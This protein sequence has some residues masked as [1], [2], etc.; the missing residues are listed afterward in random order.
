MWT[1]LD[2]SRLDRTTLD[3][4]PHKAKAIQAIRAGQ[5][6]QGKVTRVSRVPYHKT[7]WP[8]KATTAVGLVPSSVDPEGIDIVH[9]PPSSVIRHPSSI[10]RLLSSMIHVPYTDERHVGLQG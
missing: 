7:I 5:G 9:H 4:G 8:T 10:F 2:G 3:R 1:P 6:R